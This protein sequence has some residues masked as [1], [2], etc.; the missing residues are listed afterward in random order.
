METNN[1]ARREA[2]ALMFIV[3]LLGAL[4]GGVGNHLWAE[5]VHGQQPVASKTGPTRDQVV[6]NMT[7]TLELTADQQKQ[8]GA[9]IDNTRSRW[10]ALYAP[11]DATKEQIRQEG[12]ANIRS[13]L[14]PD[15][16]LRFDDYMRRLDEQRKK[17][18]VH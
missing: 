11:L 9:I 17:E 5:R 4:L 8:F 7:R 1:K 6:N 2:A 3:F 15:Q 10:Q 18:A 14:T 13:I 16:Q 12:R